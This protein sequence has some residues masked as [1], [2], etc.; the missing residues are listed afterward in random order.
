MAVLLSNP[1]VDVADDRMIAF[2]RRDFSLVA[3]LNGQ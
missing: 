3:I 2:C 1:E